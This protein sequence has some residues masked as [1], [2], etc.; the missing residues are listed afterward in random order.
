MKTLKSLE[1]MTVAEFNKAYTENREVIFN[2]INWKIN[3]IQDAEDLTVEVFMKAERTYN[4][5]KANVCSFPSWLRTVAN[6]AIVD[7]FRTDHSDKYQSVSDFV[8][9]EGD[10]TFQFVSD[11]S[12]DS[13]MLNDELR[14]KLANAFRTL[15]PKYRKI[16]M[17][18]FVREKEYTEIA[19]L[20]NVPMGTVKGMISRCR[21]MLQAE[22]KGS[23]QAKAKKVTA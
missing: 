4:K 13:N 22:L 8:N 10:E 21:E 16:A 7:Y 23:Y 18:Y 17:L 11:N 14:A 2:Y 20:C 5:E 9:A 19:E 1:N 6:T 15:K 12:A 3:S